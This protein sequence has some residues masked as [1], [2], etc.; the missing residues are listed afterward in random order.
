MKYCVMQQHRITR[1]TS[2]LRSCTLT[3]RRNA[4]PHK[5]TQSRTIQQWFLSGIKYCM[6]THVWC[7]YSKFF[8]S[9]SIKIKTV[10]L[11][12]MTSNTISKIRNEYFL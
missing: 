6:S 3:T 5:N 12:K 10:H 7:K 9:V 8:M 11:D 2:I 1:T 4:T